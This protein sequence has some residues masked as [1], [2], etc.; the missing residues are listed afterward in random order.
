MFKGE[1][2]Q[3]AKVMV[4]TKNW[5]Q[6]YFLSPFEQESPRLKSLQQQAGKA[7]AQA[8]KCEHFERLDRPH[9]SEFKHPCPYQQSCWSQTEPSHLKFYTHNN[10]LTKCRN[11]G[12][13][14]KLK[15]PI[16][17]AQY[18]HPGMRDYMIKC[19]YGSACRDKG[20][21]TH[22]HKYFH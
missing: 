5:L 22:D 8:Q 20:D 13:C 12:T 7:C 6:T 17:R 4:C 21:L 11:A 2:V 9:C 3:T 1:K 10:H 19:R 14:S 18:H 15:D 16:H